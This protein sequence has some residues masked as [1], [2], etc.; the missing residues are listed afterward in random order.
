[1][2]QAL[3]P[4]ISIYD[5]IQSL[6]GFICE[7]TG[8]LIWFWYQFFSR[9]IVC[10]WILNFDYFFPLGHVN[11]VQILLKNGANVSAENGDK[12]TPLHLAAKR[13]NLLIPML[14]VIYFIVITIVCNWNS[15][16]DLFSYSGHED[17]TDLLLK[18]GANISAEDIDKYTP[19]HWAALKGNFQPILIYNVQ[20][21]QIW[22]FD[23]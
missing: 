22:F 12:E 3:K 15:Y 5:F 10:K 9:S 8:L 23:I 17:V 1:M 21:N 14:N 16:F 7:C 18:S 6:V 4:K 19:L 13:G 11:V 2:Q 20:I